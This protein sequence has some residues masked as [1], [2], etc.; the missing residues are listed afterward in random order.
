MGRTKKATSKLL[1]K[2]GAFKSLIKTTL[3]KMNENKITIARARDDI[4]HDFYKLIGSVVYAYSMDLI[5]YD[6]CQELSKIAK[7]CRV[8]AFRAIVIKRN[9]GNETSSKNCK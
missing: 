1:L 9:E 7:N 6:E 4:A 5:S 2:I 3:D 8:A